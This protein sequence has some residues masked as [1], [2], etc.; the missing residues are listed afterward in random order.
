MAKH[1]AGC[2]K[3]HPQCQCL[4]CNNDGSLFT[5]CIKHDRGCDE[6]TSCPEYIPEINDIRAILD[7]AREL[8]ELAMSGP[9]RVDINPNKDFIGIYCDTVLHEEMLVA[10]V[11]DWADSESV[12][13]AKLIACAP[14][15]I[16]ALCDLVEKLQEELD[17][18]KHKVTA[19]ESS[20]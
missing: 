1:T 13:N 12:Y 18:I 14:T 19:H 11:E 17:D 4:T 7:E 10:R 5:C 3:K 8:C 15:L 16:P 2:I 6:T 20:S 9:W